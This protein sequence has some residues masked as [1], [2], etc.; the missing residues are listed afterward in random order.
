MRMAWAQQMITDRL[1]WTS[2]IFSDEKKL[3]LND[4]DGYSYYWHD[5]RK[6]S[7][8]RMSRVLGGGGIMLWACISFGGVRW[9][10]VKHKINVDSYF[11][12][13]LLPHLIQYGDHLG[14]HNLI[15]QHD[16]ASIHEIAANT[17]RFRAAISRLLP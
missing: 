15:F 1:D 2:V 6:P 12:D 17:D 7:V 8:E 16:N 14:S 11:E 9:T 10:V 13:V 4:P 3:N 5:L